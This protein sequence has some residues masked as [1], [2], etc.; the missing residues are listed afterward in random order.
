MLLRLLRCLLSS[1]LLRRSWLLLTRLLLLLLMSGRCLKG[2]LG[3]VRRSGCVQ[4]RTFLLRSGHSRGYGVRHG[5]LFHVRL[6]GLLPSEALVSLLW[7]GSRCRSRGRCCCWSG[8][9]LL[10]LHLRGSRGSLLHVL[11][12]LLLCVHRRLVVMNLLL[13]IGLMRHKDRR[14]IDLSLCH[15]RGN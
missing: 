14:W 2:R 6:G 10:G 11:S 3:M 8:C 7:H 9:R 1:Q 13:L 12:E 15:C 5:H 4:S